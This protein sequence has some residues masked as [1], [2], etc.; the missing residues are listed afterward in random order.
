MA[1]SPVPISVE[2]GDETWRLKVLKLWSDWTSTRGYCTSVTG[3]F[4]INLEKIKSAVWSK[5]N[6]DL[7]LIAQHYLIIMLL[8]WDV[9]IG[10]I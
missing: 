8:F 2:A 1:I 9:V 10:T 5:V 7:N 4:T 6:Q 3:L